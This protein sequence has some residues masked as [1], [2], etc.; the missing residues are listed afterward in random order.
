MSYAP[1]LFN[2]EHAKIC[3]ENVANI[4]MEKNCMG[5][6][7]LDPRD[8]QYNGDYNNDDLTHGFNYH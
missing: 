5:I 2:P 8:K 6:K 7:T 1:E 4:L 3:L